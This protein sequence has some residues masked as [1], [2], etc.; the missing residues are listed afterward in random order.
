MGF[1]FGVRGIP[2]PGRTIEGQ[3]FARE[4]CCDL[5]VYSGFGEC[6]LFEG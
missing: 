2:R 3:R 6:A 1:G 5:L 4:Y